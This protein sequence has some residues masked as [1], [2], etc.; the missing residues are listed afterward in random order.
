MAKGLRLQYL[1]SNAELSNPSDK[2]KNNNRYKR[3]KF[4]VKS[5]SDIFK[6]H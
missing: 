5:L 3:Q 4:K 1:G 6:Y 2:V